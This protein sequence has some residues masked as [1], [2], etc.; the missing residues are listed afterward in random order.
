MG[1]GAVQTVPDYRETQPE[2]EP[3]LKN[4]ASV[5]VERRKASAPLKADASR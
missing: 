3:G 2:A 1:F 5:A 4:L